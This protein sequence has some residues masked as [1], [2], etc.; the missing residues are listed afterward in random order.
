MA[1]RPRDWPDE[2]PDGHPIT[3]GHSQYGGWTLCTEPC[4]RPGGGHHPVKC[5]H[6]GARLLLGH[7]GAMWEMRDGSERRPEGPSAEPRRSR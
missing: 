6:C 4:G 1:F 3:P 2:C 7:S 5:G